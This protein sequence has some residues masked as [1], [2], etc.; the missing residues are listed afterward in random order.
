MEITRSGKVLLIFLFCSSAPGYAQILPI[1]HYSVVDGLPS[2][3][4]TTIVQDA[5]G[6]LWVGGDGGFAVYDGVDFKSYDVDEGLPVGFV[7]SLAESRTSPGTMYIGTNGGGLSKFENGKI[8]SRVLNSRLPSKIGTLHNTI[9]AIYED[10]DGTIWCGT[11]VGIYHVRGDSVSFFFASSDSGI[12]NFIKRTVDGRVWFNAGEALYAFTPAT[13]AV[14]HVDLGGYAAALGCIFE[15][16]NRIVWV[17]GE[18]GTV[19]MIRDDRLVASRSTGTYEVGGIADDNEGYLWIAAGSLL[20]VAKEKFAENEFTRY[21]TANGLPDNI[22]GS[23]FVDREHN[24]WLASRR[25]GLIKLSE[26]HLTRIPFPGMNSRPDVLNHTAVSDRDG[27]LFVATENGLREIWRDENGSWTIFLHA[28]PELAARPDKKIFAHHTSVAV[29]HDGLLWHT[30]HGG[31]L[32][33]YKITRLPRQPSRLTLVKKL[34]AGAELPE[35]NPLG[36]TIDRSNRI[37]YV[38]WGQGIVHIDPVSLRSRT[39]LEAETPQ[40]FFQDQDGR[41]WI[42][43]YNDGVYV[44][45]AEGES[46]RLQQHFGV[47]EGLPSNRVRAMMQRRNGDI[48]I[49]HRF[50]GLSIYKDGKF[51]TLTTKDGLLHNAVWALAEDTDGQVWIGTSAGVQLATPDNAQQ[52][53]HNVHLLDRFVEGIGVI[54]SEKTI[55]ALCTDELILYEY[56]RPRPRTPPPPVYLTGM[57]VNGKDR[58][59]QPDLRLS[60][61]ENVCT[62]LFTGISFKGSNS[63]RYKYRLLGTNEDWQEP[64][65]QRVVTYASLRPGKYTFEVKAVNAEGLESIVPANLSFTIS[66]PFWQRWWFIAFCLVVL[67]SI[68]YATHVTRV[69]RLLEIERIRARIATDLHDDIGAGLTHIGLLSQVA[70]QKKDVRQFI[71]NDPRG[72]PQSDG[73]DLQTAAVAIHELA[74]SMERMGSVARELSAA[75]SDVVWSINP[76]HDSGEALHRRLSVFAHEICSAKGMTLKFELASEVAGMKLN[77]EI[78]RNFLL[79]AKEALHNAAKYS[80]SPSVTVEF[81]T[82]ENHLV[83]MITDHGRGFDVASGKN[84][85][86]LGN[87]RARAEKLGGACEIISTPGQGTRVMAM[88]PFKNQKK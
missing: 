39:Y 73:A 40:T 62:M 56:A 3:W 57:R 30:I 55:W 12:V 58:P 60:Y 44:F 17:G 16:E 4:I 63:L 23:C 79:I 49:G 19:H 38:I 77:P 28:L 45:A 9:H 74:G 33:A 85:N 72:T 67:A 10:G 7:W 82:N 32:A 87:M 36:I 53:F 80:A 47:T 21:T 52:L 83:V 46:W 64:I 65:E 24:L 84:G 18:D 43:T 8:T 1:E 48:W 42:G 31:G 35:G 54:T 51:E 88:V 68:L 71:T 11:N 2:N 59:P 27:R 34:V 5:R 25:A 20:R 13:R 61:D 69:E 81:L 70:L 15:D 78:R 75:M 86:G 29:S 41:I 66:P 50:D 14:E 37:W 76:K 22:V 6:Y 26:R